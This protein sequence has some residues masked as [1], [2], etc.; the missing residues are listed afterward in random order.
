MNKVRK[1]DEILDLYLTKRYEEVVFE[2]N[3][4]ELYA[5]TSALAVPKNDSNQ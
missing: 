4:I 2:W 5:I 3:G 1:N